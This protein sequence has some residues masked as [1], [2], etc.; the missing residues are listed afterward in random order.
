M[1]GEKAA[2]DAKPA[3]AAA[4]DGGHVFAWPFMSWE[5]MKPRGGSTRGAEVT[6]MSGSKEAWKRLQEPG[7]EKFER[8]RRAMGRARFWK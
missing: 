5:E 6:R 4:A 7:L 1:S 8:D 2:P 3:P